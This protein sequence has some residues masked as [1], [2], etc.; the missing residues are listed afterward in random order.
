MNAM[1]TSAKAFNQNISTWNTGN[2]AN[3]N[4]IFQGATVF[5]QN[6]G[7]WVVNPNT[8]TCTAFNNNATA[9]VLAKPGFIS[10]TP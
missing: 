2:V 5:N 6:L 7:G 1:F 4:Y 10:C 3:M 9:W 8:T